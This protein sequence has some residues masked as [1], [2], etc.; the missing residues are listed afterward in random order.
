M[1]PHVRF[2]ASLQVYHLHLSAHAT[3][4]REH[5]LQQYQCGMRGEFSCRTFNPRNVV[6]NSLAERTKQLAI[7]IV[8]RLIQ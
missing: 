2:L 7:D 1:H 8:D 5:G 3:S 6:V 4:K